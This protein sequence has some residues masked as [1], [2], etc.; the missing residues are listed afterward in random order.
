MLSKLTNKRSICQRRCSRHG[1][2]GSKQEEENA[3]PFAR[4]TLTYWFEKYTN[5]LPE[6]PFIL[7][8]CYV[9]QVCRVNRTWVQKPV[10][11]SVH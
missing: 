2:R 6:E 3:A 10:M 8:I 7:A 9:K 4:R 11:N 5:S 1:S